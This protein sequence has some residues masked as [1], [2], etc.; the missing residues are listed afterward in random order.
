M[1]TTIKNLPPVRRIVTGINAEG[2]SYF[3]SDGPSP[4]ILTVPERPGYVVNNIWQT[5]ATPAPIR[6][7]DKAGDIRGTKPPKNGTVFRFLDIPP[8]AKDPEERKRMA[9]ATKRAIFTDLANLGHSNRHAAHHTTLTI[10]YAVVIEGEV[11]ALMDEGELLMRPGDVLIQRGT[12]HAWSNR[13][14]RIVRILFVLIDG[15]E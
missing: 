12:A 10:D 11:W 9:E 13:T 6:E 4:G 1:S 5:S 7:P 8:E 2:K 14:D 15:A 3:V